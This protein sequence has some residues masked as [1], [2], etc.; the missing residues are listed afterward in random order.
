VGLLRLRHDDADVDVGERRQ[1]VAVRDA[2]V[3]VDLRAG[4]L[5]TQRR[6]DHVP[7]TTRLVELLVLDL[8]AV[9]RLLEQFFQ[10][11]RRTAGPVLVI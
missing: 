10:L 2:A 6:G 3:D 7:P 5:C 1:S 4:E 11:R 9:T 8:G